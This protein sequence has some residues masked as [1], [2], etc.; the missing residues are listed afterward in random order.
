MRNQM[1]KDGINLSATFR[2]F[3]T[4][5]GINSALHETVPGRVLQRTCRAPEFQVFS[6]SI[7]SAL[8]SKMVRRITQIMFVDTLT[9]VSIG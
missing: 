9:L 1:K 4:P 7:K 3:Q 6:L 8:T 2:S 5:S